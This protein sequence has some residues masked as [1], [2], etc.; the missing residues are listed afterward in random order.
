[1]DKV[2][3]VG[4]SIH[5][6][7]LPAKTLQYKRP[8]RYSRR[9]RSLDHSSS[10]PRK[11]KYR[12]RTA[13]RA[14]QRK[15]LL[16]A[17]RK[18]KGLCPYDGSVP[19]AGRTCCRRCIDRNASGNRTR[20]ERK[21]SDGHCAYI[22]F[23][24]FK[25][26]PNRRMCQRHL[27]SAAAQQRRHNQQMMNAGRCIRCGNK[28]PTGRTRCCL[29]CRPTFDGKTRLQ[30]RRA[31]RERKQDWSGTRIIQQRIQSN[32]RLESILHDHPDRRAAAILRMRCGIDEDHDHTLKEVGER[33]GITRER[34]RQIEQEVLGISL[35]KLRRGSFNK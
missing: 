30:K 23:C 11:H 24:P 27:E 28:L 5:N 10:A 20:R 35:L 7:H 8:V 14:N 31:A 15:S 3:Q 29:R 4:E 32:A 26:L 6:A 34:V 12:R 13:D 22:G 2:N 16:R 33:F 19:A 9:L 21:I 25:P 18:A 1:M 17:E